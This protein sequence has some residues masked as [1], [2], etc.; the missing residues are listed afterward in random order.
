MLGAPPEA[1]G[2]TPNIHRWLTIICNSGP[3]ESTALFWHSWIP[4]MHVACIHVCRQTLIKQFL[5]KNYQSVTSGSNPEPTAGLIFTGSWEGY[6]S[7]PSNCCVRPMGPRLPI[8]HHS[9]ETPFR[10]A[11][12]LVPRPPQPS[13]HR[14]LAVGPLPLSSDTS[15]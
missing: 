9:A 11:N 14:R 12:C 2:S 5:K 8:S 10:D 3:R 13:W 1:A 15:I 6:H 7:L 4:D